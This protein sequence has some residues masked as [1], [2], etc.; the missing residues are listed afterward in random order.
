MVMAPAANRIMRDASEQNIGSPS[1]CLV[2]VAAAA[3]VFAP[4]GSATHYL[5]GLLRGVHVGRFR[6]PGPFGFACRGKVCH[7]WRIAPVNLESLA[8]QSKRRAPGIMQPPV[9]A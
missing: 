2:F 4:Q 6:R 9:R 7:P 3:V 1:P 5:I 8:R